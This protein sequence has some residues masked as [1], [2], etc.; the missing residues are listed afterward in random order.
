MRLAWVYYLPIVT[1]LLAG[2]FCAVLV[3]RYRSRPDRAHLLWWALGVATYGTGTALES[4]IT[5]L[6][7]SLLLTKAWYIAGALLG[8]Y[9]LAQGSLY[10]LL[11]RTT[12]Q[13]ATWLTL[14][15][16]AAVALLVVL[17]P[18]LAG[19]LEPHR[20]SGAI[21]AWTWVRGLTPVINVY[22]LV[23]LVGGAAYS[24]WCY[25]SEGEPGDGRRALG[26]VCIAIGGTLPAI[27]G[28]LAKSGRVEALYV[29]ELLGL[30]LICAGFGLNVTALPRAG[31]PGSPEPRAVSLGSA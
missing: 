28:A 7:N 24:A 15:F 14:P 23:F 16:V 27:G 13:R 18:T 29:A 12:A 31:R 9:P 21:L 30:S 26:N 10:F 20:P 22:A 19:A 1:T 17:S 11:P 3:R 25:A 5:L 6:G 4:T 8:G 2:L